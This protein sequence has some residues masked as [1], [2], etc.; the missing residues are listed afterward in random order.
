LNH[1]GELQEDGYTWYRN[2]SEGAKIL[3]CQVGGAGHDHNTEREDRVGL[4]WSGMGS[5]EQEGVEVGGEDAVV[6][7]VP[8]SQMEVLEEEVGPRRPSEVVHDHSRFGWRH[9]PV[10]IDP[11]R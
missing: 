1:L 9:Q 7:V 3:A 11:L 2:A 6:V 8:A 5:I 10:S 4:V